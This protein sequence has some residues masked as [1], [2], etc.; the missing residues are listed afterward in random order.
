MTASAFPEPLK[1]LI[2]D[3]HPGILELLKIKIHRVDPNSNVLAFSD[4]ESCMDYL[5]NFKPDYVV[6]D[7]HIQVGKSLALP[8]YCHEQG[9]P[10]MVY[11]SYLQ[12][13]VLKTLEEYGCQV[14]VNKAAQTSEL[15]EGIF[16]L[17]ND[18]PYRCGITSAN[19]SIPEFVSDHIP[20]PIMTEAEMRVFQLLVDGYTTTEIAAE[21]RLSKHTVKNHCTHLKVKNQCTLHEL[22]RRYIYWQTNG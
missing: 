8:K 17:L 15:D 9:I 3:D 10:F 18:L 16:H 13:S 20:E 11:T 7:L 6:S 21:L 19:N 22:I 12:H 2:L 1:V 14:F 5:R 4:V